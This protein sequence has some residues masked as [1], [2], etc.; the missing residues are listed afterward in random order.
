MV[1]EKNGNHY[2]KLKG[3]NKG[4]C[5]PCGREWHSK[6]INC[7]AKKCWGVG[8]GLL[9]DRYKTIL[10]WHFLIWVNLGSC[11]ALHT[12]SHFQLKYSFNVTDI[13]LKRGRC[14]IQKSHALAHILAVHVISVKW[15]TRWAIERNW[16]ASIAFIYLAYL[17][18][19]RNTRLFNS[20]NQ[21]Y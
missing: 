10:C 16:E 18:S 11:Y 14:H 21:L 19:N 8:G 15:D 12:S 7:P 4:Q 6:D 2:G 1:S 3:G 9:V 20:T 5:G 13:T 17:H